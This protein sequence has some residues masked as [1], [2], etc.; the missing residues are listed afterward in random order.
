MN[1]RIAC[2]S[3]VGCSALSIRLTAP[4]TP[5]TPPISTPAGFKTLS[6]GVDLESVSVGGKVRDQVV[7]LGAGDNRFGPETLRLADQRDL[8]ARNDGSR[9]R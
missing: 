7:A 1:L 8:R 6:L 4:D 5:A 2:S 3:S 9:F